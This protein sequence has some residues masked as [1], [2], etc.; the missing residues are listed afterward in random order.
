M[1]KQQQKK[2]N[3]LKLERKFSFSLKKKIVTENPV[4]IYSVRSTKYH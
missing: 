4:Q 3:H 1:T 2:K